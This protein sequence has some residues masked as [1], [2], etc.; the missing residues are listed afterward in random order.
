MADDKRHSPDGR[1]GHIPD[2]PPQARR[3]VM[4][5]DP[6]PRVRQRRRQ[7]IADNI[8]SF[9]RRQVGER[10]RSHRA[11]VCATSTAIIENL[12]RNARSGIPGDDDWA[13]VGTI[14]NDATISELRFLARVQ[15]AVAGADGDPYRAAAVKGLR[16]LLEAQYPNGGWPQVYPLAGGYHDAVTFND[17]A[18]A[19]V[20]ELLSAAARDRRVLLCRRR[21]PPAPATPS[22]ARST[23]S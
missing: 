11:A 19:N 1:T 12:P 15:Q 14:D 3:A 10:T 4:S 5:L 18:L 22:S 7:S 16:Y 13:Y 17:D 6:I 21:W 8:V 20:A 2:S 9:R 23:W